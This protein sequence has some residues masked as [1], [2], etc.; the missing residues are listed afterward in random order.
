MHGGAKDLPSGRTS[1]KRARFSRALPATL[2]PRS[3]VYDLRLAESRDAQ[4]DLAWQYG[5][6]GFCYYN[7]WL[8]GELLLILLS[9]RY[10]HHTTS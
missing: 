4:A 7:C 10:S 5:V 6:T 9:T 8:E 2:A 3:W 1:P